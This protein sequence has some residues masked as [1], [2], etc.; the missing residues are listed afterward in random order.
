MLN[1]FSWRKEMEKFVAVMLVTMLLIGSLMAGAEEVRVPSSAIKPSCYDK[2]DMS[3]DEYPLSGVGKACVIDSW[4]E[5]NLPQ[6]DKEKG[7]G[8]SKKA[9]N[10]EKII[11]AKR[12]YSLQ[13]MDLENYIPDRIEGFTNKESLQMDEAMLESVGAKSGL[14]L[15]WE[16]SVI[17]D[18]VFYHDLMLT[19]LKFSV[20]DKAKNG[21][22]NAMNRFENVNVDTIEGLPVMVSTREDE[23]EATTTIG[24]YQERLAIY[25]TVTKE[26]MDNSTVNVNQLLEEAKGAFRDIIRKATL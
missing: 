15:D 16:A 3:K 18:N 4:L 7:T 9:S 1:S 21:I 20:K 17:P 24:Y 23:S 10:I 26:F 11:E 2:L 6:G 12:T 13:E 14:M 19:I 8:G 22:I 25:L 5:A